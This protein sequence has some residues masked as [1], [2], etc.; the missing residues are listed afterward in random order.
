MKS[1]T[2]GGVTPE[3]SRCFVTGVADDVADGGADAS[4]AVLP[5]GG[6]DA[7]LPVAGD[8]SPRDGADVTLRFMTLRCIF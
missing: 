2:C 1:L 5:P 7:S 3:A 6:G 8:V 4:G